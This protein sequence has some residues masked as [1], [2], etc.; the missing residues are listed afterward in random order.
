MD[1]LGFLWVALS[2]SNLSWVQREQPRVP[3][4]LTALR[5]LPFQTISNAHL[6]WS[7]TFTF[8]VAS[9]GVGMNWQ[10]CLAKESD[11]T[12]LRVSCAC[13]CVCFFGCYCVFPM[14]DIPVFLQVALYTTIGVRHLPLHLHNPTSS[15]TLQLH[16]S[17]WKSSDSRS[18]TSFALRLP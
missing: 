3:K 4:V 6:R 12:N 1:A 14:Y 13:P 11:C 18:L 5:P 2:I 16:L 7:K 8:S 10:T 15:F 9:F 17:T